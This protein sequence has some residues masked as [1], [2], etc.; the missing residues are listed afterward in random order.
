MTLTGGPSQVDITLESRGPTIPADL[1][2]HL[3]DPFQI[4]PRPPGTPRRSIGLGLF[5]FKV[6]VTAHGGT[7]AVASSDGV[8]RFTAT[9]PRS[10]TAA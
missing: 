4:G 1:L 8:T 5:V 3:F 7:V 10:V 6:L 9:L 2:P